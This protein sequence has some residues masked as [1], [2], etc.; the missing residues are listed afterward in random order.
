MAF[1]PRLKKPPRSMCLLEATKMPGVYTCSLGTLN[2]QQR[3]NT[4][5]HLGS[6][7]SVHAPDAS[8]TCSI[9]QSLC[10]VRSRCFFLS[11]AIYISSF[12]CGD[13]WKVYSLRASEGSWS[14]AKG[15]PPSPPPTPP[16]APRLLLFLSPMRALV[17]LN[18]CVSCPAGERRKIVLGGPA[19]FVLSLFFRVLPETLLWRVPC[20]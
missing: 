4:Q 3:D 8:R 10:T 7:P 9:F 13:G 16:K 6:L 2:S 19:D 11:L 15:L 1:K 20:C 5:A 14:L 12:I 18:I 17:L